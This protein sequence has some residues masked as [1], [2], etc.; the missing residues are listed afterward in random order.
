MARR[1]PDHALDRRH[2]YRRLMALYDYKCKECHSILPVEHSVH[3]DPEVQCAICKIPMRKLY[4][5]PAAVF[6]GSGWGKDAR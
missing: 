2:L 1:R 6:P 3:D 4:S 5:S